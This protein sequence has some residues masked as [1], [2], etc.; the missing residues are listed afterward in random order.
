MP[1]I[2][3]TRDMDFEM[4]EMI[5][6]ANQ[7][8][9]ATLVVNNI[10]IIFNTRNGTL[11]T[12]NCFKHVPRHVMCASGFLGCDNSSDIFSSSPYVNKILRL[13][14]S[15]LL[16]YGKHDYIVDQQLESL[17]INYRY[18]SDFHTR[19][20]ENFKLKGEISNVRL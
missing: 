10:K 15:K 4:Q 19:S 14:P 3:I 6:L 17:G 11:N 20:L 7:L 13:M 16:I 9:V 18:Y 12:L 8:F 5:M 2:T 1:D